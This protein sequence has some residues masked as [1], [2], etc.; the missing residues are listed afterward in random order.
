MAAEYRHRFGRLLGKARRRRRRR[1]F[2]G[3]SYVVSSGN[4]IQ[5]TLNALQAITT[6]KIISAPKVLVLNNHTASLQVGDQVPVST[7]SFTNSTTGDPAI[8]TDIQYLPT[9]VILQVTPRVNDSGLVLL[10]ISQEVSDVK[11][12][13]GGSSSSGN[14]RRRSRTASSRARSRCMTARRSRSAA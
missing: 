5:A 2:P 8:A 4:Q 9:G 1:S 3:F 10:D 13:T 11:P 7:G 14:R 6:I 12:G